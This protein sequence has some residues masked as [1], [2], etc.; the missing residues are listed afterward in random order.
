MSELKTLSYIVKPEG[1][2][3]FAEEAI[4]VAVDDEAGSRKFNSD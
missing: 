2:E 1:Q 4:N 3:L